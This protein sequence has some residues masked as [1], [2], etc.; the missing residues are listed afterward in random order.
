MHLGVGIAPPGV[1]PAAHVTRGAGRAK[2]RR[3]LPFRQPH[4]VESPG[5]LRYSFSQNLLGVRTEWA[6]A[7]FFL[8]LQFT[9]VAW[10]RRKRSK[11]A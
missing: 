11:S 3:F 6:P 4:R 1:M 2:I 10:W 7:R 8:C 5:G 9:E